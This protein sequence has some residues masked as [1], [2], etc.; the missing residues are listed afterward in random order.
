[1][2]RT[3]SRP[4]RL[5][6]KM[7]Q[8]TSQTDKEA[9]LPQKNRSPPAP[10]ARNHCANRKRKIR[11][12]LVLSGTTKNK[13]LSIHDHSLIHRKPRANSPF[14]CLQISGTENFLC[15]SLVLPQHPLR[16]ERLLHL[17]HSCGRPTSTKRCPPRVASGRKIFDHGAAQNAPALSHGFAAHGEPIQM[18][19]EPTPS[20][21]RQ[22]QFPRPQYAR[23][24]CYL[25]KQGNVRKN[26]KKRWFVLYPDSLCYYKNQ[27]EA[28]HNKAL[29][30]VPL[31]GVEFIQIISYKKHQ[32]CI[33][34]G[35]RKRI[36]HLIA[37]NE[38]EMKEWLEAFQ[39]SIPDAEVRTV[40]E[41][42]QLTYKYLSSDH[43]KTS[44]LSKAILRSKQARAAYQN[45][46]TLHY[47]MA[48]SPMNPMISKQRL[49]PLGEMI[50]EEVESVNEVVENLDLGPDTD[51]KVIIDDFEMITVIGQGS[52]G[53]VVQVLHK[54]TK[55]VYAMKSLNK[56]SIIE[57]GEQEHTKAEK[58]IL[59]TVKHPYLMC[60]HF[61]FQTP[62][63]LYL[64]MDFV[65]GGELFYHLQQEGAFS[66]ERAK[67]YAAE[68]VSGLEYLHQNG[69]VYRD[70]KPENI[71][72]DFEGHIKMIDFGLSKQGLNSPNA[73]TRTFC[74]TPEY[75]APEVLQGALY[76]K[77]VDWWSLGTFIFEMLTGLPPFYDEDVQ[78]MYTLKL[79]AELEI[80]E[81]INK[82]AR[83]LITR[84]LD[85]NPETRLQD[86]NEIKAHPW[87]STI[88]WSDIEQRKMTPPYK[89]PVSDPNS[90]VCID[91]GF[92]GMTLADV[93]SDPSDNI[94]AHF[95]DFTYRAS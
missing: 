60:L 74:G 23:S 57:R 42:D 88:N 72:L 31:D 40:T 48:P 2:A 76:G 33:A 86:I 5:L 56:R 18:L 51:D 41:E 25:T 79:T 36:Y 84:F 37:D 89:P 90:I 55:Q 32:N 65:N 34:L 73:R 46:G 8:A 52:F 87:F 14:P 39:K 26:W 92:L 19:P 17:H 91:E 1:M 58:E 75:L 3:P 83:D 67:F 12:H 80:P 61:S 21:F 4:P 13:A 77:V 24:I 10:S 81:Y 16:H 49:V 50:K 15:L 7:L 30:S 20:V 62:D 69:I 38:G 28:T 78:R 44:N 59:Q 54:K 29:R 95:E 82:D 11:Q 53:K 71:L 27:K 93:C 66:E 47:G 64:V 68:I 6:Q 35:T 70:L 9:P 63:K 43:L 85:K 45:T 94:Q 22:P